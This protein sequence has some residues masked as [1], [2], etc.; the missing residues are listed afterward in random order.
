MIDESPPYASWRMSRWAPT[1]RTIG[2]EQLLDMF[3]DLMHRLIERLHDVFWIDGIDKQIFG[4]E[5]PRVPAPHLGE[6]LPA[7]TRAE[8]RAKAIEMKAWQCIKAV[9]EYAVK[10]I[11]HEQMRMYHVNQHARKITS[12][13]RTVHHDKGAFLEEIVFM[14]EARCEVGRAYGKVS[15][16]SLVALADVDAR[17]VRNAM[18]AGELVFKKNGPIVEFDPA[19]ARQWLAGRRGYVPTK[20]I[21]RTNDLNEIQTPAEF[22]QFVAN[23]RAKIQEQS[24]TSE[25]PVD[26]KAIAALESGLF[27]LPLD[28]AFPLADYYGINRETF[29]KSVMRVFFP[30][31]YSLLAPQVSATLSGAAASSAGLAALGGGSLAAGDEG[32]AVVIGA[33][34]AATTSTER[35]YR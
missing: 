23:I 34:A 2:D 35:N 19:S 13:L 29:L 10:G 30:A 5:L 16:E 28:L 33:G 3:V 21:V 25:P 9:H 14:S 27:T 18:A 6:S 26:A 32:T 8:L 11:P 7:D 22:G 1:P 24:D 31:Q 20:P 15:V 12:L 4:I 17:T